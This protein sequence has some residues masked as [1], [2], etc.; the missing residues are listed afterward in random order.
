MS[1]KLYT[2]SDLTVLLEAITGVKVTDR[3]SR[4]YLE[5][6]P[7]ASEK[8]RPKEYSLETIA[9]AINDKLKSLN[10]KKVRTE[11]IENFNDQYIAEQKVKQHFESL[12]N[13]DFDEASSNELDMGNQ[14]DSQIKDSA[15]KEFD[16]NI[17]KMLL[18]EI[19]R[20]QGTH[21]N[22]ILYKKDLELKQAIGFLEEPGDV[23]TL[24]EKKA[25]RR[26]ENNDY[27]VEKN[28]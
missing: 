5:G 15:K 3:S 4:T 17:L 16:K 23:L 10:R 24:N 20:N 25:L 26:L 8:K 7:T 19:L 13:D 11:D 28:L 27:F 18:I 9:E 12:E 1:N 6:F 21:F 22:E 2:A 14:M